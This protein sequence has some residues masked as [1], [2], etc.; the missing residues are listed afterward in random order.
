MSNAVFP[1]LLG[2][3]WPVNKTP[4]F[5]TLEHKTVTGMRKALSLQSYPIWTFEL[6]YSYLSDTGIP[7]DDIHILQ[8]FFLARY[9]KWDDFLFNDVTDNTVANEAFGIGDG[10]TTQYQLVRSYGG[11]VEPMLGVQG[12]PTIY[13]NGVAQSSSKY[14]ISTTGM[15]TFTT[16]P[17]ATAIISWP[18]EFYYRV[19]FT[20][21]ANQSS[22]V[23]KGWWENK[24]LTFESVLNAMS[25]D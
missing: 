2:Q 14:S 19:H 10:I 16:A 1:A 8:G 9:G 3:S 25:T 17:A 23:V 6:S 13:I 7:T 5:N 12:A 11:F 24:K 22:N 18:G 4:A 20:D 21:D 15:V